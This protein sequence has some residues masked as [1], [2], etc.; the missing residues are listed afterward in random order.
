VDLE[1]TADQEELR[2]SVRTFLQKECPTSLVRRVVETGEPATGLWESMVKLDWPALA[3]P[4]DAGGIGL[5]FADVAVVV[6]ELGAAIAPG[7]YLATV[8]QFAP[9]VRE[10]GTPAQRD[11]FLGA[12][13][14]SGATGTLAL[15]DHPARWRP[16]DITAR[17]TRTA[18]GWRLA[19]EKHAV[20]A[21]P[22]VDEVVVAAVV[23]PDGAGGP[24]GGG[25]TARPLGLFVVPGGALSIRQERSL[26]AS[27]PL[28]TIAL[29][30]VEVESDRALGDPGE[31]AQAAALSRA[32]DEA[33]V[34]LSL[35]TVGTCQTLFDMTLAYAKDR[36]Q[37]GVPIGS[38]QAVKHKMADCFVALERARAL[39]YHA[40]V[41]IEED[42]PVRSL[43]VSMAKAATDEC[44]RRVCRD[45]I[46]TF[47]GIAF[48]WEHDVHLFVKRATT[49]GELF[50][51]AELHRLEVARHLEV[52]TGD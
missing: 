46:Q 9:A 19:G 10:A 25:D 6:E 1:F 36:H 11:R 47:G 4:E 21:A 30:G 31:P 44:Q 40:V 27:R 16:R 39:T 18:A 12:I 49:D 32:M 50:G 37:F 38:F 26:D 29:D 2:R 52:W 13:V 24:G 17:A 33:A 5:G 3:I 28:A 48:T 34:A 20:L 23:D 43:A 51:A 8:T 35:E 41:A 15:A 22:D 14:T 42:A 45:A 7:P